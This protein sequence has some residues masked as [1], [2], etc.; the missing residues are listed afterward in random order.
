ML[1]VRNSRRVPGL[2]KLPS[3]QGFAW[4]IMLGLSLTL[5]SITVVPVHAS[6]PTHVNRLLVTAA[7]LFPSAP[8]LQII[9]RVLVN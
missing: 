6:G 5:T 8:I 1:P 9:L 3:L 2:E 7:L 4:A